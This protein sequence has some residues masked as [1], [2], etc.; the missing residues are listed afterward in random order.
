MVIADSRTPKKN[1]DS[2]D[3]IRNDHFFSIYNADSALFVGFILKFQNDVVESAITTG[4]VY[5]TFSD[6][7]ILSLRMLVRTTPNFGVF[8]SFASLRTEKLHNRSS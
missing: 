4:P 7:K 1:A 3:V 2:V 8:L 6:C 5:T